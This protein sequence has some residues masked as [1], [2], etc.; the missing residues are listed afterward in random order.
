M[1][2]RA[3][4][5][6]LAAVTRTAAL[7]QVRRQRPRRRRRRGRARDRTR[8]A[9]P[10]RGTHRSRAPRARA[11]LLLPAAGRLGAVRRATGAPLGAGRP[12]PERGRRASSPESS[13]ASTP[14]QH[15]GPTCGTARRSA[16]TRSYSPAAQRPQVAVPGSLTFRGPADVDALRRLLDRVERGEL[17]RLAFVVPTRDRLAAPDLRARP[18]G[19]GRARLLGGDRTGHV[20]AGAARALRGARER[21]G[22]RRPR[23]TRGRRPRE[24]LRGEVRRRTAWSSAAG[25]SRPTPSSPYPG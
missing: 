7:Q 3:P 12:R 4:A 13:S 10:R 2:R 22:R 1:R 25:R 24:H 6:T 8:S 21:G 11:A 18:P 9:R 14:T 23:R 5:G 20:R 16:T 15:T 17:R 19:C